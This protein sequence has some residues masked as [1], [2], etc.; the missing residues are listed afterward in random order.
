MVIDPQAVQ[1]LLLAAIREPDAAVPA[2]ILN[3]A[4]GEP[5]Q[6]GNGV[7]DVDT[8]TD[9]HALGIV[10]YELLTGTTPL[11]RVRLEGTPWDEIRRLIREEEPPRPSTRLSAGCGRAD[12]A[13]S[14][15]TERTRLGK[16]MRGELDWIV[17]K[18]VS[19]ISPCLDREARSTGM[20]QITACR[21]RIRFLLDLSRLFRQLCLRM[22]HGGVA[23]GQFLHRSKSG[24][25]LSCADG[26]SV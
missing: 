5:E 20:S 24:E 19:P 15:H 11:E 7:F 18:A 25:P 9:V 22:S 1:S 16:A 12:V 14:R 13:G 8:R 3:R 17:L 21:I 26:S 4:P 23:F 10:L 2:A 6:V